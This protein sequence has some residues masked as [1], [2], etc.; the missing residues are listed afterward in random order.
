MFLKTAGQCGNRRAHGEVWIIMAEP[1]AKPPAPVSPGPDKKDRV[2]QTTFP[3]YSLEKAL[4]IPRAIVDH[5]GGVSGNP[6]QIGIAID[7][8]PTGGAWRTL[9]GAAIAYGLTEGY[10]RLRVSARSL[11]ADLGGSDEDFDV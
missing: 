11:S 6:V 10:L 1:K 9:T 7:F 8:T 5:F 2:F 4:L 3:A